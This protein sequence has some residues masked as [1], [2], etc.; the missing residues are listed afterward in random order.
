MASVVLDM[1]TNQGFKFAQQ[2]VR[3][4]GKIITIGT[5][6]RMLS[7]YNSH[8]KRTALEIIDTGEGVAKNV[9]DYAEYKSRTL[10]ISHG[11]GRITHNLYFAVSMKQAQVKETRGEEVRLSV[12]YEDPYYLVYVVEGT[13]RHIGR[14]FILIARNRELPKLVKMI[15]K[16]FDGLDFTLPQSQLISTILSPKDL[17]SLYG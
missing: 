2:N 1:T 17:P 3:D 4:A 12:K 14:N 11:L 10:G 13:S 5:A 8:Y 16:I 6:Q 9:G 15:G 7:W